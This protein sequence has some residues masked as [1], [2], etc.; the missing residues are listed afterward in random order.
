MMKRNL[1]DRKSR[2]SV[3][4]YSSDGANKLDNKNGR[5]KS[6]FNRKVESIS[7]GGAEVKPG[8]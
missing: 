8:S 4:S 6:E 5:N 7:I 2:G 3:G 1:D